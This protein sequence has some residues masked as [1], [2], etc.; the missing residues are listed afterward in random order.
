MAYSV[1]WIT[2]IVTIPVSDLE[3]VSGTRYRLPMADFLDECRR[4]EWAFIEGLWAPPILDHTNAKLDFAGADYAGFDKII[5]GYTIT[6]SAPATRVDL[7]GSNNNIIDVL[8][9]AGISVV[10]SN[11]AGLQLI[12]TGSGLS[13]EQDHKL[14]EIHGHTEQRVYI[15][16]ELVPVGD[17]YQQ[18]PFNNFN[19]AVDHAESDGIRRLTISADADVPVGRSLKNFDVE[20]VGAPKI[21]LNGQ[22]MDGTRFYGCTLTGSYT[23]FLI[24]EMGHLSDLSGINGAFKCVKAEGVL[25]IG[26]HAKVWSIASGITNVPYTIDMNGA[27][28]AKATLSDA[29]D[30]I[31]IQNAGHADDVLHIHGG[32]GEITINSSCTL[33][34]I[35]ISG[36]WKITNN[37]NGTTVVYNGVQIDP[38]QVW[39][40]VDAQF[41]IGI[42]KNLKEVKK[43]SASWY[44]IIYAVGEGSGGT[45]ILRKKLTDSA[46]A[47]ITDLAAGTLAK[48]LENS[49]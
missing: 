44:L 7:L 3:L 40:H 39:D 19:D 17:G 25:T 16:T 33:G 15:N 48:E 27:T 23:G 6:F 49:V 41:L 32:N 46:G 36:D 29:Y 37:A 47:D 11:S 2:K 5:N 8:N 21:D 13:S 26:T 28:E 1:D 22:A 12:S 45:E 10:P 30:G 43:I 20:G 31:I 9:D 35:H 34:N 24:G 18:T 38:D 4:L 42:V 14:S